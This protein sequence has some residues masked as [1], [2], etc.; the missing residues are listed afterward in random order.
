MGDFWSTLAGNFGAFDGI[1]FAIM[2]IIVLG[3]ALMMPTMSAIVTATCGA[4][5]IFAFSLFLRDVMAAKDASSVAHMDLA[6]GLSLP[7]RALLVYGATFCF[8]IAIVHVV[9]NYTKQG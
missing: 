2:A 3:A 5:V 8:S 9:R 6:Y 1:T 4:L 7:L